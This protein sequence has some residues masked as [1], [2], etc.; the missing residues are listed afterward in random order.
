[1]CG[2]AA[3][4]L[5]VRGS[6]R[7]DA[8]HASV[9]GRGGGRHE[10]ARHVP[11]APVRERER[12]GT[13]CSIRPT[14]RSSSRTHSRRRLQDAP[15]RTTHG[16]ADCGS[17]ANK[18][19]F[20]CDSRLPA[21]RGVGRLVPVER[22]IVLG[23]TNDYDGILFGDNSTG[24]YWSTDGGHSVRNAGLLP[25]VTLIGCRTTR[26]SRRA[27]IRSTSSR[28]AATRSTPRASRTTRRRRRRP[29]GVAVYKTTPATLNACGGFDDRL[30][31]GEARRRRVGRRRLPRQGVDVR[32]HAE[33]RP[34]RLGDVDG[35]PNDE[36][37][38]LGYNGAQIKAVRCDE[39]LVTCTRD[40]DLAVR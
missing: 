10:G 25:P 20:N 3:T 6:A 14:R 5:G 38:P 11:R 7:R 4:S 1:M 17:N 28:A 37:A 19:V 33:R 26:R 30:L 32:R 34:L 29:N 36:N 31:A 39:N 21:E 22:P 13:T 12:H 24:W 23:A 40:P 18:D 9:G 15:S 2:S 16:R 35:V 27:A 8:R